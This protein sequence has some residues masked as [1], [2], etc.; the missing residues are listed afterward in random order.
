VTDPAPP[1]VTVVGLGPGPFGQLTLDALA[2]IEA[3]AHCV[4]RTRRHP[5]VDALAARGLVHADCDDVY[6][7]AVDLDAAY[8]AIATS[9]CD[10]AQD[11]GRVV[12]AVPGSPWVAEST[13]QRLLAAAARRN[14]TV[15]VID[16][17]SFL[18]PVLGALGLDVLADGLVVADG[19]R[20]AAPADPAVPLVV[21]QVD[22]AFVLGEVKLAL[23]DV[24]PPD[25]EVV[26]VID[27]G[28]PSPVLRRVALAEL[29]HTELDHTD[30]APGPRASLFVPP[31]VADL[32]FAVDATHLAAGRAF[33]QLVALQDRL[34]GPGGCPWDAEQ[35]H[36]SLRPYLLEE[37]Y[38]VADAIDALPPDAPTTQD[39][40]ATE[41]DALAYGDLAEELGDFLY[42]AVFHACLA[43]EAGAFDARDVIDGVVDKL[44]SRHPHVFGDEVAASSADVLAGWDRRKAAEKGRD[45]VLDGLPAAAPALVR[46]G[47]VLARSGRVGVDWDRRAADALEAAVAALRASG[48]AADD[49]TADAAAGEALLALTA[50]ARASGADPEAALRHALAR[51]EAALR[52]VEAAGGTDALDGVVVWDPSVPQQDAAG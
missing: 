24:Y 19:R 7:R 46:A 50:L 31:Y 35:T 42:Q 40:E 45:S 9:V 14:I 47:K 6:D 22:S 27:A 1:V 5:A 36:R 38:E 12:Y 32:P 18:E 30:A 17:L 8:D 39:A 23:L 49:V 15:D 41:F 28:A 51:H 20:V 21:A 34:R 25:H 29:D 26:L 13:V 33:A 10:A 44:V 16:G 11:H 2:A 43:S 4:V 3:A 37:T 52:A 48:G